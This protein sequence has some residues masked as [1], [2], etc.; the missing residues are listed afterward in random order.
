MLA[1]IRDQVIADASL[2]PG[3]TVLDVGCGDGLIGFTAADRVGPGGSV[4]LSDISADLLN[5]CRDLAADGAPDT[6]YRFVQAAAADLSAIDDDSVDAVTLRSV[7]IYE[8]D[9]AAAFAEFRRV[10]RPGG[11][12][13]LFEPIN[14]FGHPEPRDRLF[15]R[16]VS[17]VIDLADR[18]KSIY[19]AIQPDSDPM[20][21]FDEYDLVRLAEQAGFEE[22]H[23]RL[24]VD[25]QHSGPLPWEVLLRRS[26]NPRVPTLA[27]A[28]DE[29]L[30][31]AEVQRLSA[32]LRPQVEEGTGQ[33]RRAVAYVRAT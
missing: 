22:V 14:R 28:M 27:E 12:L 23:L 18:V 15:G 4:I 26:G 24:H 1:P 5:R 3:D 16:D 17:P 7:L 21:D 25:V 31:R 8:P 29:A 32:Q 11:R 2:A 9:K 10:L 20:V 33:T 30:S 6:T 19:R 13:S